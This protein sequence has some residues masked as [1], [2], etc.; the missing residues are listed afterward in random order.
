MNPS[1]QLSTL[2]NKKIPKSAQNLI[3]AGI[4]SIEELLWIL[5][6]RIYP[7]PKI[8][9]FES[10]TEGQF[11]RGSGRV[12]SR[13][14]RPAFRA[15]GKRGI[16][17]FVAN[18]VLKDDL[19]SNFLT[20]TWFNAYPN[21]MKQLKDV[22]HLYFEGQVTT[23]KGS[24]Q[25]SNPKLLDSD[26]SSE[27]GLVIEYP[28]VAKTAGRF[29]KGFIDKV[30]NECIKSIGI[31]LQKT[32]AKYSIAQSLLLLH[33]RLNIE[34]YSKENIHKA[35]EALIYHEF[36]EDQLKI[37]ARKTL[38]RSKKGEAIKC[39]SKQIE[40]A[41]S[42]HPFQFTSAQENCFQEIYEDLQQDYPMMRMVQGDVGCGKTALAISSA[43][44]VISNKK[45][46][47][48]MCPT[49]TLARQQYKNFKT[50]LPNCNIGLLLGSTKIKERRDID[51]KCR[52]GKI[53]ILIGTHSLFQDAVNFNNLKLVIIDEQHKFGVGQRLKLLAKGDNPHCLI[54]TATPIPRSLRLTQFGDLEISTV[55]ELPKGRKGIKTRVVETQNY[56]KY[57]SFLKTRLELGE[58]IFVVVPAIEE[59]TA[60][61]LKNIEEVSNQYKKIFSQF[62]VEFLH[63]KMKAE[64][65]DQVVQ[66]FSQKKINLL[67]STSVI[68]VG[69]N[70]PNATVISIYNPERF[71]LSSL[72]QL[73][74]RV[75]RGDQMGFCFLVVQDKLSLQAKERLKVLEQT[76]D[77]FIVAEK[78]LEIRGEGDLFGLQQSG[79][80]RSS[81][82]ADILIHRD[83][84]ELALKDFRDLKS[85]NE[86]V[87][88][89]LAQK[90]ATDDKIVN[91]I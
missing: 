21:I 2:F 78:D 70:I 89:Q 53:D 19:S 54:M 45:Q 25:I 4:T 28:T 61:D 44:L 91:T 14:F 87:I 35:K 57:L 58:Q 38:L 56:N 9:S 31:E 37:Q 26:S 60:A 18:L 75:G 71:G 69:I 81:R 59:S 29:I 22:E 48:F 50:T 27:S 76:N 1:D 33:G 51:L 63:G 84:F 64:E 46:V 47:A 52:E 12:V 23:H 90:Y 8:Q 65:K 88:S 82:I 72:H 68:E 73:R 16:Q 15:R 86:E 83:I 7:T 5:P 66:S 13:S 3:D 49:E 42:I 10:A 79:N 80:T 36:F 41:K 67:V 20:L 40:L 39:T 6:L 62:R 74:G 77:G 85:Q 30:T 32:N 34:E 55:K 11:F 43:Y 17:L 24:L